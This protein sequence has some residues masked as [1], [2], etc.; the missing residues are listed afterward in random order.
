M[1]VILKIIHDILDL[2]EL[3]KENYI[4]KLM[5]SKDILKSSKKKLQTD[6]Q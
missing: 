4:S 3:K 1:A 6:T 5:N 2:H